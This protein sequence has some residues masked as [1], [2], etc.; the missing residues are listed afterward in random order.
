MGRSRGVDVAVFRVATPVPSRGGTQKS[1]LQP[2]RSPGI[3]LARPTVVSRDRA[4]RPVKATADPLPAQN[5]GQTTRPAAVRIGCSGWQYASWRG[6][7]YPQELPTTRW[8]EHYASVFDTVELNNSFYRLP[9]K[10]TFVTWRNRVPEGFL[11]AVKASRYLTHLKRLL[12]PGQPL[13][14]L[15]ARAIGLADRLGPVLYQLPGQ[16]ELDLPRLQHFLRLL[17]HERDGRAIRHAV[18][19]RHPSWYCEDVFVALAARGVTLC[20]HD[21]AGSATPLRSV[22]PF[23]YVRFHGP[24]GSYWGGYPGRVLT[25]WADWLARQAQDGRE[26]FGYFNNDPEAQAPHDAVALREQIMRR[27]A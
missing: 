12:T 11:F 3:E 9:E 8:L 2:V 17:P 19:F 23:V 26:V 4:G 5:R 7:F 13:R 20:L 27:I 14:R 10:K 15:F 21:R 25:Q 1:R 18:E 6:R 22:G 24:T 16:L